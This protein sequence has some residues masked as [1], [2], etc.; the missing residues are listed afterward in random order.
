M[1]EWNYTIGVES[2]QIVFKNYYSVS[3]SIGTH[4]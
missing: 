1:W 2:G 4:V 3:T